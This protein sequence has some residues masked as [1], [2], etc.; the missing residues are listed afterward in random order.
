MLQTA[1][2]LNL[3]KAIPAQAKNWGVDRYLYFKIA[4]KKL[5]GKD[6]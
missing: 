3:A 6:S 4:L 5:W 2:H 1:L